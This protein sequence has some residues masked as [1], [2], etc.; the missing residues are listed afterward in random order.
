MLD[1]KTRNEKLCNCQNCILK[2]SCKHVDSFRRL[3][4][5]EGGLGYCYRLNLFSE[6]K[7]ATRTAKNRVI[8]VTLYEYEIKLLLELLQA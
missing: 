8:K 6:L 2:T 3:P 1:F 5:S 7:D 4:K